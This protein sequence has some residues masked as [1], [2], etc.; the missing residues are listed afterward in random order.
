MRFSD[1]I[2]GIA[3]VF[4]II[5]SLYL[6]HRSKKLSAP[7]ARLNTQVKIETVTEKKKKRRGEPEEPTE[8]VY[9]GTFVVNDGRV[10]LATSHFHIRRKS[11]D[12]Y[13]EIHVFAARFDEDR[14]KPVVEAGHK[15]TA[16]PVSGQTFKEA[17][18]GAETVS[19]EFRDVTGRIFRSPELSLR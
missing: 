6:N 4:T 17:L 3:L 7:L 19:A 2:A 14:L 13:I 15:I 11:Y 9:Q 16:T 18:V 8:P 5:A 12:E 10:E 1:I